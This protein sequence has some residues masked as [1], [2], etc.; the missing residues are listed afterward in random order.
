MLAFDRLVVEKVH[1]SGVRF[2]PLD[3][4][5]MLEI[6]ERRSGRI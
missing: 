1:L 2:D 4:G 6:P 3:R 5:R